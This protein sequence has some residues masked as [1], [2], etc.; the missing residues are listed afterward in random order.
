MNGFVKVIT[1]VRRCGKS[2]LLNVLFRQRLRDEG[3]ADDHIISVD[4]EVKGRRY[5]NSPVKYYATDLGL[6]NARLNMR[7]SD[8]SHPMENV[9]F[10]ELL[11]RG[12]S[13]D[14]GVVPISTR[15]KNGKQSIRQHEIDFVV[16]RGNDK[17]YIQ[18][19]LR[20]DNKEKELQETASL[21]G[22]GDFFKKVVVTE[23]YDEPHFDSDGIIRV[24]VLPFLLDE[25]I[26][27][28]F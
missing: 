15:D 16:N 21:R 17:V 20:L 9:L 18:S 19:A 1:G 11:R 12:Y 25:E 27:N 8:L 23:G 2:Y 26:M 13:V 3:V 7:D 10:N 5:L 28:R 6:R 4:L 14:V 22:V 24:S